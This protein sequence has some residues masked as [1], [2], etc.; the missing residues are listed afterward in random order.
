M[1]NNNNKNNNNNNNNDHNQNDYANVDNIVA[2]VY[3]LPE[4]FR[5]L[6]VMQ[7]RG[8]MHHFKIPFRDNNGNILP[9][10]RTNG[11]TF[12]TRRSPYI[13]AVLTHFEQRPQQP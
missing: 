7:M 13:E 11:N 9:Q 1:D 4:D 2:E 6:N 12:V 3:H 8:V 5:C 10:F